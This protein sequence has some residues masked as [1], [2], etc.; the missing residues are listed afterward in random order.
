MWAWPRRMTNFGSRHRGCSLNHMPS[1]G[2]GDTVFVLHSLSPPER[3]VG[4]VFTYTAASVPRPSHRRDGPPSFI[5]IIHK[6][7]TVIEWF[8]TLVLKE[9]L[10]K[11][12]TFM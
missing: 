8:R 5:A 12:L 2:R 4:E 1:V 3:E 7:N 10:L 9:D 6:F 11:R